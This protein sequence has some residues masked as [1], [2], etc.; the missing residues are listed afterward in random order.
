LFKHA[1]GGKK[2]KP[3]KKGKQNPGEQ[4]TGGKHPACPGGK[5]G[6][7]GKQTRAKKWK[8]VPQEN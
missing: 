1:G 3:L 2:G 5:P 4:K 7:G 6:G 8:K